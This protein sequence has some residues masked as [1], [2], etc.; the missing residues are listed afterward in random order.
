MEKVE[1]A[2]IL[3]FLSLTDNR[4]ITPEIILAW[5]DLIGHLHFDTA[6]EAAH[7]AKQDDKIN[8]VEP[9]HVL[10]KARII[11]DRQMDEKRRA[12]G[13]IQTPKVTGQ[14]IPLCEHGKG[15]VY[16]GP[17]CVALAEKSKAK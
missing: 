10:G 1:T 9:K 4:K 16:C 14:P 17:C 2:Q 15:I 6:R 7:V 13:L 8:W 12:E 3:E 5:H 11:I